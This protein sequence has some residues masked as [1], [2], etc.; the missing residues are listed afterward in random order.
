M[1]G[2]MTCVDQL[3][4]SRGA[5]NRVGDADDHYE[6]HIRPERAELSR[7]HLG[8]EVEELARRGAEDHDQNEAQDERRDLQQRAGCSAKADRHDVAARS[9]TPSNV[10]TCVRKNVEAS[11]SCVASRVTADPGLLAMSGIL[12]HQLR[13]GDCGASSRGDQ[14]RRERHDD[15]A[16]DEQEDEAKR[17]ARSSRSRRTS[18]S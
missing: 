5:T 8:L 11:G 2:A 3:A 1:S 12:P 17:S 15:E 13:T 9:T 7:G 6:A 16:V 4:G 14:A 10:A 18:E